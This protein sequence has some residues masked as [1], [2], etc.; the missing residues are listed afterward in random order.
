[1]ADSDGQEKTEQASG[2][3]LT[4][5]RSEGKVAKSIEFNSFAVFGGGFTLLYISQSFISGQFADLSV[6][7]FSSLDKLELSYQLVQG[8]LTDWALFYFITMSP[9]LLGLVVL[10]LGVSIAQV[11]FKISPKA[12][13]PKFDKFNIVTGIKNTFFSSKSFVELAKSLFKLFVIG[14]IIYLTIFDYM[15]ESA[16][17]M[18]LS[19][20]SIV[21]F[22]LTAGFEVVWKLSLAYAAIAIADFIFQKWKFAKDGMMTKQEVKEEGKQTEGDPLVKGKIRGIQIAMARQRMMQEIP[23]AD[24]VI[25]NPTHFAIAL[26]YDPARDRSPK[27][28]AK[29]VDEVAQRI[30]KIALENNVPLHEDRELART[31]YKMCNIGDTIPE[32]LFQAVAKILAYIFQLKNSKKK[33]I[34]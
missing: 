33:S 5:M 32:Q 25:T 26:R 31:L 23:T 6:Q 18:D 12:L 8:Y 30:K 13:E 10:A 17:F 9:L 22:M 19:V 16:K 7:I 24:V 28:L 11:G 21:D 14:L 34:V 29:G 2:K 1:M 3:K 27:V 20:I 4:D 15:E